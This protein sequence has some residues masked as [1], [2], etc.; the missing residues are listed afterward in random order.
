MQGGGDRA[1]VGV[2][3]A[4]K[5]RFRLQFFREIQ[6]F[7]VIGVKDDGLV[8][9]AAMVPALGRK[10]EPQL[11]VAVGR[12]LQIVDPDD[13]R[14]SRRVVRIGRDSMVLPGRSCGS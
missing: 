5:A 13:R 9:R 6:Q 1:F 2:V 3:I 11:D 14:N 8:A 4:A 7:Q 12:R 10:A